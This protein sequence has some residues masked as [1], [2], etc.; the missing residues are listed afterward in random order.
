MTN[1]TRSIGYI[2]LVLFILVLH[3]SPPARPPV[4]ALKGVDPAD[5]PVFIKSMNDGFDMPVGLIGWQPV[6]SLKATRRTQHECH[7]RV[8]STVVPYSKSHGFRSGPADLC[9]DSM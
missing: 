5:C 6:G 7:R 4:N 8:G 3:P 9:E 2:R 1:R